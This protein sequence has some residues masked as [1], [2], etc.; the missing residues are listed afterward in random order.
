MKTKSIL[1]SVALLL[2]TT[3]FAQT[4][5]VNTQKTTVK[6]MAEKVTGKHDGFVKVKERNNFV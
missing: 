6:W 1:L 4:A 5:K 2:A 3:T